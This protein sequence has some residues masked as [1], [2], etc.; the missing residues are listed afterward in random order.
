M[1]E[2]VKLETIVRVYG[3][4]DLATLPITQTAD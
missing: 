1:V 2:V 3:N 4:H